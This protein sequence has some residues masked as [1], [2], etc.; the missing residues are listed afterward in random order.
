MSVMH[1]VVDTSRRYVPRPGARSAARRRRLHRPAVRSRGRD[2][3]GHGTGSIHGRVRIRTVWRTR[4][5]CAARSPRAESRRSTR[6]RAEAASGV[7]AVLTHDNMPR[8]KAPSL[9]YR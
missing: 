3:E 1:N 4:R 6:R 7:M 9:W 5:W 2:A 8:M